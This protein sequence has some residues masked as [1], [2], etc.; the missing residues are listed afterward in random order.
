MNTFTDGRL[1]T[2]GERGRK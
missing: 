1:H 2:T